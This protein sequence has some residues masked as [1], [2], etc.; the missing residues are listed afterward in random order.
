[1]RQKDPLWQTVDP[2]TAG[3]E[4]K[5]SKQNRRQGPFL[6]NQMEPLGDKDLQMPNGFGNA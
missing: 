1:M 4:D 2:K 6:N 3:S 5:T